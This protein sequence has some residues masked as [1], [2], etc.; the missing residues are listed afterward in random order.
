MITSSQTRLVIR[1][2][3]TI[4]EATFAVVGDAGGI[5]V[6]P[7]CLGEGVTTGHD[8]VAAAFL[9]QPQ[10]PARTLRPEILYLHLQPYADRRG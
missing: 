10:F 4:R 6:G 7:Q 5:N 3:R 2:L 9:V 1:C 8:V